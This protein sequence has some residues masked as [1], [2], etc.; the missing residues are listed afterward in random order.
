MNN[1]YKEQL[2]ELVKNHAITNDLYTMRYKNGN[3]TKGLKDLIETINKTNITLLEI[4]SYRGEGT[5]IFYDS[6]KFSKIYCIDPWKQFYSKTDFAAYT[7]MKLV[8]EEFD[9][10]F[11]NNNVIVK[12]KGILSDF[13]NDFYGLKFDVCYIDGSHEYDAV[14]SDIN[15]I[16]NNNLVSYAIAGHD[17]YIDDRCLGVK[18]AIIETIGEPDLFFCDSSWIK[19][20]KQLT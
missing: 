11:K 7:N 2:K 15:N 3:S 10:K 12:Y 5:Q 14:K 8:E 16:I 19:F 6:G 13:I 1:K 4:G 18:K 9:N 17:Y 20:N